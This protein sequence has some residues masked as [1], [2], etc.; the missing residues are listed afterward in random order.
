MHW[1]I[2][3]Y[4]GPGHDRPFISFKLDAPPVFVANSV[5]CMTACVVE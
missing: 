1:L 5:W 2:F 4:G 3:L